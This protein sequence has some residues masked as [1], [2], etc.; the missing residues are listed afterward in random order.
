[1]LRTLIWWR[2]H[3]SSHCRRQAGI[4]TRGQIG[5]ALGV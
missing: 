5:H 2:F 4:V 1:M 3:H